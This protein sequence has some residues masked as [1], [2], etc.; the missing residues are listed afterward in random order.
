MADAPAAFAEGKATE[1]V[2]KLNPDQVTADLNAAA[3]YGMKLPASSGKLFVVGFLL[4]RRAIFPI[5]HQSLR[6]R[7]RIRFLRLAAGKSGHGANQSAG[8][9]LLCRQ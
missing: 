1:A 7:R 2:S 9:R 6:S 4:G 8:L 3:D 5:R